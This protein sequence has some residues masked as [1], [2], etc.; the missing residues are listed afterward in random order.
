MGKSAVVQNKKW[1]LHNATSFLSSSF[2]CVLKPQSEKT[3]MQ[4]LVRNIWF[5]ISEEVENTLLLQ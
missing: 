2:L 4:V 3:S 1:K 5:S